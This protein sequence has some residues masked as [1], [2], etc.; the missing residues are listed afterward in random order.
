M[1][2]Y[3]ETILP[4]HQT[5]GLP[6]WAVAASIVLALHLG[7]GAFFVLTRHS[8]MPPGQPPDAL[9]IDLAPIAVAPPQPQKEESKPEPQPEPQPE[10][11]KPL[12]S[13][14]ET[15]PVMA[16]P[17]APEQPAPAIL[18][19]PVLPH[20]EAVVAPPKP[21]PDKPV[22]QEKEKRLEKEKLDKQKRVEKRKQEL[23]ERAAQARQAASHAAAPRAGASGKSLAS[24]KSELLARINAAKRYPDAAR[25]GHQSGTVTLSFTVEA[26]GQVVSPR[27]VR[28]SGSPALDRETLALAHRLGRLPPPP[29]GR[30]PITVPI[31]YSIQ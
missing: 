3:T 11:E 2:L 22:E 12:E 1:S 5:R 31:R 10:P 16:A 28:S 24:W 26:S 25:E 13:V 27:I 15:P 9:M 19:T 23:K 8:D 29:A 18:Q 17:L 4:P 21:V 30:T 7:I 20:P 6:R 14:P